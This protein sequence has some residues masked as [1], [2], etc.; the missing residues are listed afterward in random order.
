MILMNIDEFKKYFNVRHIYDQTCENCKYSTIDKKT[1]T[2]IGWEMAISCHHP[3]LHGKTV[4]VMKCN[5]CDAWDLKNK[6]DYVNI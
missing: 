6:E 4:E 3:Q 5:I 1:W 2:S